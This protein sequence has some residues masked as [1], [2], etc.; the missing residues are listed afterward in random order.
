MTPWTRNKFPASMFGPKVLREQMYFVEEST[1][2][3]T[4]LGLF[5]A[6]GIALA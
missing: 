1:V 5:G 4:L 2:F 6:R 3:A